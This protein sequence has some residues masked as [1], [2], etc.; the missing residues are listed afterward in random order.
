MRKVLRLFSW[1][2]P[3]VCSLPAIVWQF[4]FMLTPMLI[5]GYYS[6]AD[7]DSW[8]GVSFVHYGN[9]FEVT[10]LK[11]I[12]RS[13]FLA[14]ATAITGLLL[15]YPVAYF[16]ALRVRRF[17]NLM[18]FLLTLPFWVNFLVQIYAWYFLLERNGLI[19]G[20][21]LKI[22]LIQ[23]PLLLSNSLFA[24]FIVML[25]CYLPFVIMPIYSTLEKIDMRLLEASA[26]LGA[27]PSQTFWRITIPYSMPGIKTGL[28][29]V[30]IPAFGEFVIPAL[31]G[32]SKYMLVGSLISY[33]FL[34]A[35]NN[36]AGSAFTCLSGAVLVIMLLVVM[37]I[38]RLYSLRTLREK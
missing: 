23:E 14:S 30:M 38:S 33:Y 5:I 25:N 19:N 20:L 29:L 17:K 1:E 12:L 11:I 4:F 34:A 31:V 37:G 28:L 22:G 9:L 21:L 7:G 32:G 36:H 18:L 13:L 10:Y 6:I 24:V 35:R 15:A 8:L 16:I 3:F 26:D 27:T 2:L